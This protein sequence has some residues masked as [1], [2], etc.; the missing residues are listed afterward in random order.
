MSFFCLSFCVH[1][2]IKD[3]TKTKKKITR[4]ILLFRLNFCSP[5]LSLSLFALS[6]P[7]EFMPLLLFMGFYNSYVR[8]VIY[9]RHVTKKHIHT[10]DCKPLCFLLMNKNWKKKTI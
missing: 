6:R 7:I 4:H 8:C 10:I 2:R 1:G 3:E 9:V 5:S